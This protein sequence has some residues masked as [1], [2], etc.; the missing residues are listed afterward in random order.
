MYTCICDVYGYNRIFTYLYAY[1]Y[2]ASSLWYICIYIVFVRTLSI[3]S[4]SIIQVFVRT[5]LE[6]RR[7]MQTKE[8]KTIVFVIV[9]MYDALLFLYFNIYSYIYYY[10][11]LAF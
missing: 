2:S 5:W 4:D 9:C 8:D 6:K 7:L 11:L 10:A 3:T 1:M